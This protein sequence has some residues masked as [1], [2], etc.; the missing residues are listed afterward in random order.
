MDIS[1]KLSSWQA[2]Y[3]AA[4][5][6]Y[7]SER[8]CVRRV[9]REVKD[10][11]QARAILQTAAQKVQQ[12]AHRRIASVVSHCLQ[13]IFDD[14]YTFR[15]HF[16]KKRGRTEARLEFERDGQELDASMVGGG[17]VDVAAFALRLACLMLSRPSLSKVLVLDEPWKFVSRDY[18]PRMRRLVEQLSGDLGIQFVVVSHDPEFQMGKV[19]ELEQ[20]QS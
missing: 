15:I 11:E 10:I 13:S 19:I 7:S 2:K 9:G 16:E 3:E 18:R 12:R 14:P 1:S 20:E 8:R 17:V 4:R 5:L 6:Q